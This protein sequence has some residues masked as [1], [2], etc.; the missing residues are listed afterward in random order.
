MQKKV[1]G[2]WIATR[3]YLNRE[4]WEVIQSIVADETK[5]R[6]RRISFAAVVRN[7]LNKQLGLRH[8]IERG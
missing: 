1:E 4:T 6:S 5:K 3:I 2:D 7:T 8:L